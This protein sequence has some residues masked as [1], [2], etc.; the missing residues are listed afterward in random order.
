MTVLY[1]MDIRIGRREAALCSYPEI[2][3]VSPGF[4]RDLIAIFKA[5]VALK[6]NTTRS[7]SETPNS[8]AAAVRQANIVSAAEKEAAE[9]PRPELAM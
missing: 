2:S 6:V 1:C 3:T 8:S 5:W 4:T 9:F 7:G